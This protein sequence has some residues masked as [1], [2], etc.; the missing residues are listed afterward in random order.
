MNILDT[1]LSV[2]LSIWV[3]LLLGFGTSA[4][5]DPAP[6]AQPREPA[7]IYKTI[8]GY[9]HGKNIGPI[10]LGRGLPKE[11]ITSMARSGPNGM[12]AFR[13]TEISND[14]LDALAVFI[15]QSDAAEGEYGQ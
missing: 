12:P 11:Y 4:I 9:C 6:S 10:I 3:A 14:E 8:C 5:A 15:S 7:A 13:P 2:R 1:K